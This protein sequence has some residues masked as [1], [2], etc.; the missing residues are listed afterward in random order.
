MGCA[1]TRR[2]RNPPTKSNLEVQMKMVKS[3]LLGSAAGLAAVTGTQAADLPVKAKPVDYIKICPLHWEGLFYIPG[4][5][6]CLKIG[7]YVRADYGWNV[8]GARTPHYSG[9]AGAQDRSVS[10]YSTRHRAHI[11]FDSRTQTPSG[12]LRTYAAIHIDN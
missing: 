11:N 7:G 3:L 8:T 5:D 10:P 9:S 1:C 2:R 12:T 4:T 6:I